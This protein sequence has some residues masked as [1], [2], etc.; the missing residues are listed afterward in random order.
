MHKGIVLYQ[1]K[2]GSS[3]KYARQLA[4]TINYELR[5]LKETK[6][7]DLLDNADHKYQTIILCGGIYASGVAG[8]QFIR[9][10]MVNLNNKRLAVFAVGAS[11]YN[12][13]A[14]EQLKA[15]HF[16]GSLEEIPLFYGRGS[17]KM[18]EMTI[19]D[20]TLCRL[21]IRH[22]SKKERSAYEPWEEA[23]M[24]SVGHST[25]W[26]DFRYLDPII[27]YLQGCHKR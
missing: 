9:K 15:R 5:N 6:I 19:V 22:L 11:P 2:Y 16:H 26:V 20:R 3:E 4:H 1:S 8:L 7:E 12:K 17:W 23:L 14:L 13:T 18:E 27:E 24:S 10:H 25:D 21:L